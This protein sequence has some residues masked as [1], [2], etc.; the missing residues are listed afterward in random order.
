MAFELYEFQQQDIEKIERQKAG[1]IGS[2]MGTGKTHEAIAL[3]EAWW[4]KG[5]PPTLVVAPINTFPSWLEK[6]SMQSPKS[7]VVVIDRKNRGKFVDDIRKRR[8]DVFIV[9]HEAL[10]LMPELAG[11]NFNTIIADE[12]HREANRKA[13]QT[14]ALKKLHAN[15]KLAMSGTMSGDKPQNLWSILNWL[16]PTFYRSYWNFVKHY[17]VTE[18]TYPQG[19]QK[20]VGVKNTDSLKQEMDPWFVRHLKKEQC[21]THHPEGVMSW[22][23]DKTYDIM[24]VDLSPTQKR[25]YEQM[26]KNMVAWVNEHEDSPLVASV[27]VA[28]L[29]RL[30][31]MALATPSID[32]T[33]G[34]VTLTVPS[35]KIDAVKEK[36]L[37]SGEKQFAV[38]TAS[39]QAAY[40]AAQEFERADISTRVLSGDTKQ[41]ERDAMVQRFVDKDY[42]V[43]VG[44][45]QAAGEGI[46]GLQ[47][48]TDTAFFLDRS[49]STI[50]NQQAE[51]RLHRGGTK[52]TVQIIDVMARGTLDWGRKQRLD[53]KWS[54]IK[55][56]LGDPAKAQAEALEHYRED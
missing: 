8:G 3:D 55:Q 13:Q 2:E 49:W 12:V 36:I 16:Y 22:L 18:T 50:R 30:S 4:K 47:H 41:T 35:S 11:L 32:E 19:Y 39:K 51:D 6:Y 53:E 56:I 52:D 34:K 1:A 43:F 10:R 21:C 45:I 28:Q 38:F 25:F 33:T 5:A 15:Y 20:I 42:Q 31:Q 29:T 40:L 27:V 48:A 23:P 54:W 14:R 44:V 46:D 37:D 24:W 17:L 7:D 9:H 26:R